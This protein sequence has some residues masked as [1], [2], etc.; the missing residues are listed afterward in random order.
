MTRLRRNIDFIDQNGLLACLFPQS[1]HIY[2][3]L[4]EMSAD[5]TAAE[6]KLAALEKRIASLELSGSTTSASNEA[7]EAAV[8]QYQIQVL[9]RLKEIRDAMKEEG[10]DVTI[11][12]KERDA[13]VEENKQLKKEVERLQYR[14]KHL[15]KS[16][17][18]EERK[19]EGK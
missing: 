14:V 7:V 5:N 8:R 2:S 10:G 12:R 18:E 17:E 1:Q 19:H 15:V 4:I 11:V 6:N 3:K 9:A 13:A 16:L